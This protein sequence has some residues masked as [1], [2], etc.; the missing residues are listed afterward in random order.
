MEWLDRVSQREAEVLAAI[1]RHQSNA[2]IAEHLHLSVRTVESHVSALLRKAGV[3]DRRTLATLAETPADGGELPAYPTSFIGREHERAVVSSALRTAR[4]VSLVGTG[5]MGKTRL[6]VEVAA[7]LAVDTAFVDLVPVRGGG[8]DQAVARVLGVAERPPRTPADAVIDRLRSH[9]TL[10]VLD[11]CEH[12]IAEVCALVARILRSCPHVTIL[13]TSRERLGI[14]GEV[15]VPVPPLGAE[16][17]RLFL[18]RAHAVNPALTAEPA[19][20]ERLCAAVDGMP[21]AIELVAARTASLGV[22][23]L[24][25]ALQDRLRLISGGRGADHRHHS[26]D[27]V[28]GWSLDLLDDEERR[29]FRRLGVFVGGFDLDAVRALN[30]EHDVGAVA[31]LLGRLVD[32][33]IVVFQ[34]ARWWLLE[35]VRAV[36]VQELT[37]SGE[38]VRPRYVRWAADTAAGLESR[39][40]GLPPAEFDVVADDLRHALTRANRDGTAYRLAKSL[41]HLSFAR[42]LVV[43][44]GEYYRTAADLAPDPAPDFI[45]AAWA[46]L[47]ISAGET[48]FGLL[49]EAATRARH[50][51]A[52]AMALAT[53][54]IAATRYSMCFIEPVPRDRV[55]TLLAEATD[56]TDPADERAAALLAMARAWVSGQGS[57]EPDLELSRDAAAA[58]RRTG[59]AALV[60]GAL[61]ALGTALANAGRL[62]QAHRLSDERLRLAVT[63]P[64][65]EPAVAAELTDL[66]HVA[67]TSAL[68]AGDLPAARSIAEQAVRQDLIGVHPAITAPRLVRLYGLTGRFDEALAQAGILWDG[69]QH[70]PT[71]VADGELSAL[72]GDWPSSAAAIAALVNGLRGDLPGFE[73]WRSRA[74]RIAHVDDAAESSALAAAAAFADARVAVHTG[75]Y[76]DPERL[77]DAALA[78]FPEKWWL[79]YA[80]AAGAELAVV[81]GLP[82]AGDRLAAAESAAAEN[83]WA[84]A[85]LARA[86][87]RHTGDVR[88]AIESVTRWERIGARFERAVTLLLVPGRAEEGRTE[89]QALKATMPAP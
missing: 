55:L 56:L 69:W 24:H 32:R 1:R 38:D 21:L 42:G 74:L 88:P 2:Q 9:R 72:R 6:A 23:G 68:A 50:P 87:A 70:A 84:A 10:L 57:L 66:F 8:V 14:P 17:Q 31:D 25:V 37:A 58:A 61:D 44:A 7:S 34:N 3:P 82:D 26:L 4:L 11:N 12:V 86:T 33:S 47:T 64:R 79:A 39:I 83:D 80:H 81:A 48:A 28:I 46:A 54:A 45:T 13:A 19:A 41:A 53:A 22:D 73:E 40:D 59:D 52:R 89:L 85:C 5:G 29:L 35:T 36:A 77:V 30:P 67:S 63:A 27:E 51:T 18:D 43:A 65:H 49:R 16:A 75:R 15:L 76:A 62:R 78:S 20:I 71:G 60:I